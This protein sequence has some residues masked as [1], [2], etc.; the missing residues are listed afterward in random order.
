MVDWAMRNRAEQAFRR[1]LITPEGVDLN[2]RLADASQRLGAFLIDLVVMVAD[3]AAYVSHQKEVYVLVNSHRFAA[4]TIDVPVIYGIDLSS[5][6]HQGSDVRCTS[7]LL[8][9]VG[10]PRRA[11]GWDPTPK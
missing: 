10:R 4:P 8:R 2:L 1:T 5:P 6:F 7:R 3:F 9:L 11:H